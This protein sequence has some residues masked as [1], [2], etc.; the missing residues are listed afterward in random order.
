MRYIVVCMILLAGCVAEP[1][2]VAGRHECSDDL[3]CAQG[4]CVA[5]FC[6]TELVDGA[7]TADQS[8]ADAFVLPGF[9][10]A[11]PEREQGVRDGDVFV[12]D[13][14]FPQGD[15]GLPIDLD[16]GVI[17]R[18]HGVLRM[19]MG[20]SDMRVLDANPI[21]MDAVDIDVIMPDVALPNECLPDGISAFLARFLDSVQADPA[22][23]SAQFIDPRLQRVGICAQPQLDG[24]RFN[25]GNDPGDWREVELDGVEYAALAA[26]INM[27][28]VLPQVFEGDRAPDCR[29]PDA[30][31]SVARD[32]QDDAFFS[33][34]VAPLQAQNDPSM[35]QLV[36][37]RPG[38]PGFNGAVLDDLGQIQT[39]RLVRVLLFMAVAQQ[40]ADLTQLLVW[41]RVDTVGTGE[42]QLHVVPNWGAQSLGVLEHVLMNRLPAEAYAQCPGGE[43]ETILRA[44]EPDIEYTV[45]V[46]TSSAQ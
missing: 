14:S 40:E 33:L 32:A 23:Q 35:V 8:G 34:Q 39:G 10:D 24:V 38:M 5:G 26:Q 12:R 16:D 30:I 42:L 44:A 27:F 31:L 17:R 19:D 2:G 4:M 6:R 25:A 36:C 28:R 22:F 1:P 29:V 13:D 45:T 43:A 46:L 21:D 15:N 3:P 20:R 11:S 37:D 9:I 7:L 18:D 41:T